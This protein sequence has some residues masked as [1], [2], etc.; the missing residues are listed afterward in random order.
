LPARS[1]QQKAKSNA[2]PLP[3]NFAIMKQSSFVF[4]LVAV[5]ALTVLSGAIQGHIRNR[6]GPSDALQSAARKLNDVPEKFGGPQNDRWQ[7]KTA[8]KMAD[9]TVEML[10]CTGYFVRTYENRRTG[11]NI[12]VFVV[13]G[14]A[15]PIA[16]HTPEI[17]YSSQNYTSREKRQRVAIQSAQE[18]DDQFWALSFKTKTLQ[19]DLL[20][21]YYAWTANDRWSAPDDARFAF[22]GSPYLYKIQLSCEMPAGSN[23][24]TRDSCREF[25][26]DFVPVLRQYLTEAPRP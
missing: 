4:G 25:L 9:D 13:V 5:M 3:P 15:G 12:N 23:L 16:V 19:E 6:W 7:L 8:E 17:C 2:S 24:K 21:V 11:E 10:E 18:Q 26:K 14:P 20:V 22:V 1:K